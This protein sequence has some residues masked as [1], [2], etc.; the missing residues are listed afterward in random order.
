MNDPHSTF[1]P[2][3]LKMLA[4]PL[5]GVYFDIVEGVPVFLKYSQAVLAPRLINNA[6]LQKLY[7]KMTK[8][9]NGNEIK[10]EDQIHEVVTRDGIK[11][12]YNTPV[13]IHD[14]NGDM[15]EDFDLTPIALT[16]AGWKLQQDLSPKGVKSTEVGSQTMKV[17]FQGLSHNLNKEF[18]L[19]DGTVMKG[20]ELIQQI[21]DVVSTLSDKGTEKLLKKLGVNPDTFEIEN[22]E[23][24]YSSMIDDLAKRKDT[25]DNVIKG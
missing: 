18:Y 8:D 21:H 7:D 2:K 9:A 24:M 12:G 16:N 22:E 11:T 4:Q 20:S 23:V 19:S 3:E 6:P 15:L 5:K 17:I 13:D 25:P 10:Y 14:E 1:T